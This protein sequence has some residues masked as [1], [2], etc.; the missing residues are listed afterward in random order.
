MNTVSMTG[1]DSLIIDN[2]LIDDLADGDSFDLTF[3]DDIATVTIGKD[4]NAIF[5]KNESGNRAEGVIRVLRGSPKDKYLNQKLNLQ[6]QNFAGTVLMNGEFIKKVGNG[7]GLVTSDTY[8]L[9]GGLF[10]KYV[11]GKTNSTGD[12]ETSI[13]IYTVQFAKAGRVIG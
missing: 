5:S 6:Q 2:T 4:G 8:L 9:Q 7:Q 11:P 3:P 10:T 13:S 12:A 1:N